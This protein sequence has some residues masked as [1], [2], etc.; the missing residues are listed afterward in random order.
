MDMK[1]E[2]EG[3]EELRRKLVM[4]RGQAVPFLAAAMF[5][6]ATKIMGY[7]V[8]LIPVLDGIA[9]GSATVEPP[10]VGA[11]N[12]LVRFGYGGA[13]SKYVLKLHENP[14]AGKTG[15][16][17]PSGA[18]YRRWATIGQWKFLETPARAQ[19]PTSGK[20]MAKDLDRRFDRLWSG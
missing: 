20:R 2:F 19:F 8:A 1:V 17:S 11:G 6:E 9:R 15:G 5:V 10:K 7:S 16:S 4:A 12:I 13:A 3:L 14:R 18:P